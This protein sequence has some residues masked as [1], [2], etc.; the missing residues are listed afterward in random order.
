MN[1]YDEL[2]RQF[3]MSDRPYGLSRDYLLWRTAKLKRPWGKFIDHD[4]TI[5]D[6][7]GGFGVLLQFLPDIVDKNNYYNLDV[8]LEMLKYCPQNPLLAAGEAIPFRDNSFDYVASS[9]VLEH[10]NDKLEVLKECYRVLKPNG[11]LFLSTP[12]TKWF[13]DFRKSPFVVFMFFDWLLK[14]FHARASPL[15]DPAGVKDEPSD[16]AWLRQTLEGLAFKVNTQYRADNHVAWGNG[17]QSAFWR[18]FAD[19]F[20]DA[21]KYGHC[22]VVVCTK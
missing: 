6:L 13:E 10:V 12:R 2:Y 4:G 18:W 7:G 15:V 17:G 14:R 22:T 11:M 21:N 8:S 16:E 20:I 19:R 3:D 9:D 5:L 1:P